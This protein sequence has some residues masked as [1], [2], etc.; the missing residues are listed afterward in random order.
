LTPVQYQWAREIG[1]DGH[2]EM[3]QRTPNLACPM[4]QIFMTKEE[5]AKLRD[6]LGSRFAERNNYYNGF[7]YQ[8]REDKTFDH[9]DKERDE[10]YWT[11]WK[12]VCQIFSP[13]VGTDCLCSLGRLPIPHEQ[14]LRHDA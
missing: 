2:L 4:N 7:L 9:N 1:E 10:F 12:M 11:L 3:W 5:Q 14:L 6:D 13:V 8:W